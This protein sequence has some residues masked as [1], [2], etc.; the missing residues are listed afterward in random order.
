MQRHVVN[1]KCYITMCMG[2]SKRGGGETGLGPNALCL[3]SI[4]VTGRGATYGIKGERG[5]GREVGGVW[6]DG[7]VRV[8]GLRYQVWDTRLR[9]M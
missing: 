8:T 1:C 2:V 3:P 5:A 6:G 7:G 9:I 4:N